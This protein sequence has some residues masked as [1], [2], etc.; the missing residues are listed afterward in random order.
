MTV[1]PLRGRGEPAAGYGPPSSLPRLCGDEM[2]S[3]S[4]AGEL[5]IKKN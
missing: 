5:F 4:K 1:W 3:P 2:D